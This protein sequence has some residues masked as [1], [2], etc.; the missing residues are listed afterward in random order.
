MPFERVAEDALVGGDMLIPIRNLMTTTQGN[1]QNVASANSPVVSLWPKRRIPFKLPENFA[2]KNEW[3][4]VVAEF[5][6]AKVS[7]V[8]ASSDD[9]DF[10]NIE[11]DN[12]L[13]DCSRTYL[14]RVG[15][16]Q[17]LKV[18]GGNSGNLK[19]SLIH[20][21]SHAVGLI[22]EHQ[23]PDRDKFIRFSF[24]KS[25][26]SSNT[27]YSKIVN[28]LMNSPYDI[29]SVTHLNSTEDSAITAFDGSKIDVNA[30]LTKY[31]LLKV[32]L[33]YDPKASLESIDEDDD[34]TCDDE[35]SCD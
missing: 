35:S 28:Y 5:S 21:A 31:D 33:L 1:Y 15:G 11:V 4:E 27:R 29:R 7:W 25:G 12:S 19:W 24:S 10:V 6:K 9:K 32:E 30:R 3:D 23:R 14:G 26:T 16:S 2:F 22:H 8:P 13:K 17:T 18:C 34:L 20:L